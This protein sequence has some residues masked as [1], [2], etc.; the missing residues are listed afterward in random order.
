MSSDLALIVED[1]QRRRWEKIIQ[2]LNYLQE[3]FHIQ[4]PDIFDN[5]MVLNE[6]MHY[7]WDYENK[8]KF[9]NHPQD[10]T[11]YLGKTS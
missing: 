4:Q 8:Y 6:N 10:F 5:P 3:A 9:F 2:F 7:L 11:E 1:L